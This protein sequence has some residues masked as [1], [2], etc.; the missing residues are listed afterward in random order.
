MPS[1]V[2][3]AQQPLDEVTIEHDPE[4]LFT[5]YRTTAPPTAAQNQYATDVL[6]RVA[7]HLGL[8]LA[9][10]ALALRAGRAFRLA[11]RAPDG[12]DP[13]LNVVKYRHA[14]TPTT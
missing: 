4:F 8:G 3:R 9:E 13:I 11:L 12:I 2:K 10:A 14:T 7:D 6:K 5:L 1:V